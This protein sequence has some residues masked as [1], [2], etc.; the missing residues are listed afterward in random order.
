M[1]FQGLFAIQP[2]CTVK[3]ET[4]ILVKKEKS[5]SLTPAGL[6]KDPG[7]ADE[8]H[9]TPDIQHASYLE[10]KKTLCS[11]NRMCA[12]RS[13]KHLSSLV[14]GFKQ[15]FWCPCQPV[16]SHAGPLSADRCYARRLG[17]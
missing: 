4:A 7:Q 10:N 5:L 11:V 9:H 17:K 1:S 12:S 13:L 14:Y 8:E 2:Y 6:A 3:F 15:L 16:K